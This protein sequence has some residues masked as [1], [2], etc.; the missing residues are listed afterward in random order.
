MMTDLEQQ[1]LDHEEY[2][3]FVY[4]CPAGKLTV[5]IGRNLENKGLTLDESMFLLRNDIRECIEDLW[6]IFPNFHELSDVKRHVL[7]DM[8]FNLGATGFRKFKRMICAVRD[9]NFTLAAFE[10]RDSRWYGQV[11]RRGKTLRN[12]MLGVGT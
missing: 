4:R 2:R 6:T 1:L 3:Q 5:G 9:E 11:G 10:M 8:R 7:I 12:M